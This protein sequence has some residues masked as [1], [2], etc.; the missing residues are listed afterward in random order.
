MKENSIIN[1]NIID[2]IRLLKED[3]KK[4]LVYSI[5]AGVIGVAISFA[6][7][8]TYKST[9]ML[10]PEESGAGFSG[11]LSSIASLVGM[12]MKIGQTGDAL[13]PEIYPDLVSSSDFII[14]LFPIQVITKKGD[15]KC[16]YYD[17]LANH[18]KLGITDYPKAGIAMLIEKFKEPELDKKLDGKSEGPIMLS[19][20]QKDIADAINS[21]ISCDVDKKTNVITIEVTDQ[22]PLIAATMADSVKQHLQVAITEYKTKKAKIDVAYMEKLFAEAKQDYDKARKAYAAFVDA[23]VD[24]ELQYYKSKEEDLENELQLKYNIYQQVFEQLQLSRAKVQE[25]TPAFTVMQSATVPVKHSDR[26]KVIILA[27]WMILGFI[28]RSGMLL[29]KNKAKFL[30]L[31]TQ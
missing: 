6:T 30:N 2:L 25:R 7:P 18:Q 24:I 23:N 5:V 14:G 4:L 8:H 17:Y 3:K 12:N 28:M 16:T 10:A 26:P 9:V 22:D 20:K 1:I 21:N 19:R 11:S 15:L 29:W 31:P 27:I 13:Y